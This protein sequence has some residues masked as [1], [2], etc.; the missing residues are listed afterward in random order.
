M[1][2]FQEKATEAD[3]V[4]C[5]GFFETKFKNGYKSANRVN[6]QLHI[7]RIDTCA[8]NLNEL[9]DVLV[10]WCATKERNEYK[11]VGWYQHAWVYRFYQVLQFENGYIQ[12]FNVKA[13]KED[14]VLLPYEEQNRVQWN[15]PISKVRGYGFGQS[16]VWYASEADTAPSVSYVQNLVDAIHAYS[17]KN[18]LDIDETNDPALQQWNACR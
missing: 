16:L 7:E 12:D 11:V 15:A 13:K 18:Y 14:C 1:R 9:D 10:V 8:K 17:G 6:N 5:Y 3:G 4:N 2:R